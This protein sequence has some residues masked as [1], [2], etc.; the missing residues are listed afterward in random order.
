MITKKVIIAIIDLRRII[1]MEKKESK[2]KGRAL[3]IRGVKNPN[4]ATCKGRSWY[5]SE[6]GKR[7]YK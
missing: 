1:A 6:E 5:L 3:K 7:I 4:K 2:M